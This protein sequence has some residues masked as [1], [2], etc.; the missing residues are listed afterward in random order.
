MSSIQPIKYK[1]TSMGRAVGIFVLIWAAF[2]TTM[3]AKAGMQVSDAK[4]FLFGALVISILFMFSD[5]IYNL[6]H[7]KDFDYLERMLNCPSVVGNVV[8]VKKLA[9]FC[10]KIIEPKPNVSYKHHVYKIIA[11]FTDPV[12]GQEKTTVS[13]AYATDVSHSIKGGKVNVHYSG[14]GE[15]WIDIDGVPDE[16]REDGPMTL[17][18]FV[19]HHPLISFLIYALIETVVAVAMYLFLIKGA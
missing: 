4:L 14:E 3:L 13:E 18:K 12:S 6:R 15:Y 7:K 5:L 9:E 1:R 11:S 8:E 19:N 2:I 10:G 17:R 16:Y